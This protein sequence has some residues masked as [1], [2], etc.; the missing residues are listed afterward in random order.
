[1][2]SDPVTKFTFFVDAKFLMWTEDIE[3]RVARI[4]LT[5]LAESVSDLANRGGPGSAAPGGAGAPGQGTP[6]QHAHAHGGAAAGGHGHDA[7]HAGHHHHHAASDPLHPHGHG[8]G[9]HG[10]S[11]HGHHG[12]HGH[13]HTTMPE[14]M[15]PMPVPLSAA[16]SPAAAAVAAAGVGAGMA[17]QHDRRHM[18]PHMR[19]DSVLFATSP[20]GSVK[21]RH[22][23]AT[24]MQVQAKEEAAVREAKQKKE[25]EEKAAADAAKAQQNFD[26]LT[27]KPGAPPP[28]SAPAAG[29]AAAPGAT[30]AAAA[31]AAA[32][33]KAAAHPS[34]KDTVGALSD[35]FARPASSSTPHAAGPGAGAGAAAGQNGAPPAGRGGG[36]MDLFTPPADHAKPKAP[37][38]AAAPAAGAGAAAAAAPSAADLAAF[39]K[40]A[41]ASAKPKAHARAKSKGKSKGKSKSKSKSGDKAALQPTRQRSS[42]DPDIDVAELSPSHAREDSSSGALQQHAEPHSPVA[43][44][45]S[46]PVSMHLALGQAPPSS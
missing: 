32:P 13:H 41:A 19:A 29:V 33:A 7:G 22:S 3:I 27:R 15:L 28:A 35:L 10:H 20:V 45:G 14:M 26:L 4:P 43:G 24:I 21:R 16:F 8:G 1:M 39:A 34:G 44:G 12:H 36:L 23:W 17:M 18:S 25:A 6:Q 30:A 46:L 9:H 42:S 37:A 5:Q 31:P 40:A 38:K 2:R 11:S